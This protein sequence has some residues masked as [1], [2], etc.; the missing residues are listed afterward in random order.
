[1]FSLSKEI[2]VRAP[3][4]ALVAFAV[5]RGMAQKPTPAGPY[6]LEN[7]TS[8]AG[9]KPGV[10][11]SLDLLILKS[12]D[13]SPAAGLTVSAFLSMPAMAG[14]GMETP[15]VQPGNAP[16]LYRVTLSFPH[17]GDY[18]LSLK[19]KDA[20]GDVTQARLPI[21]IGE[22]GGMQGMQ[23][24]QGM[25]GMEG[26]QMKGAYGDWPMSREGSGTSWQP[27]AS[28]MFM[29]MLPKAG[30]YDLST[31]GQ[32]QTG[33]IDAGAPR[34]DRQGYA[35]SMIMLMARRE[36][37]GGIF[38]FSLM[39][40]LDPITNGKRGVPNLFQTGETLNGQPLV[41]RQHPHDLFSEAALSYSHPI[42]NG[43]RAFLYGGPVGEPALGNVM[44]MHRASGME[45]PEA[46]ISHHW[47]DS[48]HIS[49]G[50]ATLGFT[51][52]DKWKLEGSV[53]NGHEPDE[54]RYD[55]DPIALNSASGRIS[56]NP[57][58][59]WSFSAS[60][61]F[62]R[63]PDALEP[64][65]HQH[66]LT[67][68][69]AY[70]QV[71]PNG[72]NWATTA[73]FGKLIVPGRPDSNAF[74]IEST[75]FHRRESFFA[76]YERVDKDELVGIPPGSYAINKLLVGAVHN[77]ASGSG[78]DLGIGGYLGFYS[79]PSNLKPFY[80]NPMTAGI[81]FRLRPSKM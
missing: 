77:F 30:R 4:L 81:F 76:R 52:A 1:M 42:G 7:K 80:G 75:L 32:I 17:A 49:F 63:S 16:G 64:G 48:T 33:Y 71:L 15:Q 8:L 18:E 79:F 20:A 9:I 21:R 55:I 62:L 6:L 27:D 57:N 3:Y 72:D 26:M 36:T 13:K 70:S 78:L 74:L 44:F 59:N 43:V 47:F 67:A 35:N 23:G 40:S 10:K 24:M 68:S 50:V 5:S 39:T 37:G 56:Y 29:K 12:V 41:D 19:I 73:Y 53:F 46:P 58:S 45:V 34:G 14:M 31:M 25:A 38:G 51:F 11:S 69:A 54:N 66:R 28:P 22:S 60:Y 2:F 61:G 65:V